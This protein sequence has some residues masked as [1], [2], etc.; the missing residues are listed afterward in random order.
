MAMELL[1]ATYL[2]TDLGGFYSPAEAARARLEHLESLILF[3]PYMAVV[4]SFQQCVY[5]YPELAK[6]PRHCDD[7]WSEQWQRFMPGVDWSGLEDAMATGWHR[8]L[9]IHEM[10]FYYV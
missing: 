10:P 2:T 3:W 6:D 5:E 4:D 7:C 9:H 8:K 1:A